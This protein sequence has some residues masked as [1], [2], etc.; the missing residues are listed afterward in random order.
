MTKCVAYAEQQT[1][2]TPIFRRLRCPSLDNFQ[3]PGWRCIHQIAGNLSL[4]VNRRMLACQAV[5]INADQSLAIGK[6]KALFEQPFGSQ[7]RIKAEP[8][9]QIG[10]RLLKDASTNPA[11]HICF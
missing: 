3:S 5:G 1:R 9:Q 7:P 6:A 11:D 10:R 2:P 8:V 4:A